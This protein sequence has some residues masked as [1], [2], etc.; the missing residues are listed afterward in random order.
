MQ[1]DR[2]RIINR[3]KQ[4]VS[5]RHI[6]AS[7]PDQNYQPWLDLVDRRSPDLIR[8][9]NDHEFEHGI[10]E[11]LNELASSHTAFF[12]VRHDK[13]PAPYSI[14]ATLRSVNTGAGKRWMFLDVIEAGAAYRAGIRP[15]EFLF[16]IDSTR[17]LPPDIAKFRI[18]GRQMLDVGNHEGQT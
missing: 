1:K 14:N 7:N 16:A 13:V 18:G 9:S 10:R 12:H 8:C 3:I 5:R 11:V 15:G 17:L 6:N 2:V 4:L